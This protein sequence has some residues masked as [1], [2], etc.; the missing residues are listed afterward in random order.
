MTLLEE[1]E[2]AQ[3]K[4]NGCTKIVELEN[5]VR[6]LNRKKMQIW[7]RIGRARADFRGGGG[8]DVSW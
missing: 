8:D 5:L 6:F 3:K 1:E 7:K 4:I 2:I